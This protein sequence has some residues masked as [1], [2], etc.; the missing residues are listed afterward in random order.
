MILLLPWVSQVGLMSSQGTFIS[1]IRREEDQ[2]LRG[3]KML[4]TLF[5]NGGRDHKARNLSSHYM[6]KARKGINP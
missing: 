5:E 4:V 3:L 1:E 2:S 6:P